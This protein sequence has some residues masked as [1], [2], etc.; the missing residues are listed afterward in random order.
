MDY[1]DISRGFPQFLHINTKVGHKGLFSQLLQF[2]THN[3]FTTGHYTD[4]E[5]T[6]ST[7][8][9]LSARH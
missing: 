3:R 1:P 2:I 4:F 6:I 5:Q 7:L 9:D 8:I